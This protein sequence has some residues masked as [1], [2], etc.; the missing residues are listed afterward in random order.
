MNDMKWILATALTFTVGACDASSSSDDEDT[1]PT[2]NA[3][4]DPSDDGTGGE[5]SGDDDETG[6][7]GPT[8]DPTEDTGMGDTGVDIDPQNMIDDL[9]DGDP[10]ITAANG[11]KG[12]WYTYNDESM[13]ASQNPAADEPFAPVEGGPGESLFMAHTDGSGFAVWGA[14]LGF[15]L[16]NEG[17]DMG[18]PGIRNPYDASGMSGIAFS[19]RGTGPIR[20]KVLVEAIVP[21]ETGG[22]CES[23]TDCEDAHGKIVPLSTE[24]AQYTVGFDELFQ[25]G[26][27]VA[28][29]FDVATLMAVQFQVSANSDFD[30]DID[31]VGFY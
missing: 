3:T 13:G 25:E 19:A 31:E 10:L 14:G 30:F 2:T 21:T 29:N 12:A 18:G 27:G 6:G 5:E 8:T 24:W 9:E 17:D 7:P 28:A 11:R 23:E 4:M 22:T 15:D 16:N 20:V 26:W 1:S